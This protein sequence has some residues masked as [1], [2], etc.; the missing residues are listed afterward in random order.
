MRVRL[1]GFLGRARLA[2]QI[3]VGFG[4]SLTPAPHQALDN[5]TPWETHLSG[6]AIPAATAHS[7]TTQGRAQPALPAPPTSYGTHFRGGRAERAGSAA[8]HST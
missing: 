2:V 3:D 1:L 8:S 5:H 7:D 4:D 6:L